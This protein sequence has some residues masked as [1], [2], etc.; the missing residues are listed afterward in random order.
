L[1]TALAVFVLFTKMLLR[2]GWLLGQARWG[3]LC[4]ALVFA[5]H[6]VQTE[7]VTYISGRSA[8]LS[9]MFALW[10]LAVGVPTGAQVGSQ[11]WRQVGSVVLFAL[12][13]AAKETALVLPL[14]LVLILCLRENV[15]TPWRKELRLSTWHWLIAAAAL[16]LILTWPPYRRLI[17]TSL[18][19]RSMGENLLTQA[20]AV[21]YLIGQLF[22]WDRLN[23]DPRLSWSRR[24]GSVFRR[25]LP[26]PSRCWLVLGSCSNG[27]TGL[28]AYC[29]FC[30]GWLPLIP[31]W[32]GWRLP[33]TGNC[34]SRSSAWFGYSFFL[35]E[36][37]GYSMASF[38]SELWR[39]AASPFCSVP[40]L[41]SP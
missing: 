37:Y 32:L 18:D 27:T 39:C 25:H 41:S 36:V 24:A 31:C 15:S 40:L 6:P 21:G 29:G 2:S 34:T 28:R 30:S 38:P 14:A 7:A 33:M 1:A 5:L 22:H 12:A 16:G 9:A 8:S 23:A 26:S 11:W 13:L 35:D 3:A 4:I 20:N 19:I 17:L 10:S